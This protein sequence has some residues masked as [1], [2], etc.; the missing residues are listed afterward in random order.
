[1]AN[2]ELL[3]NIEGDLE[4]KEKEANENKEDLEKIDQRIAN[5]ESA[6]GKLEGDEE[7]ENAVSEKKKEAETEKKSAEKKREELLKNV[8]DLE[9]SLGELEE[10]NSRSQKQIEQLIGLGEEMD[11]AVAVI[12]ERAGKIA[13]AQNKLKQL[14]SGLEK[15]LP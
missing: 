9:N 3:E 10:K 11:D 14:R 13:S 6:L 2:W 5:I 8:E 12:D 4:S 15:K 1:M 7:I